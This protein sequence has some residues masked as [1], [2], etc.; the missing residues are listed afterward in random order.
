M[1]ATDSVVDDLMREFP[2]SIRVFFDFRMRCAGCPITRFHTVNDSCRAHG[3][4]AEMFL[5]ALR[6]ANLR[7]DTEVTSALSPRRA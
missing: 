7:N 1:I 4:D 3:I 5:V 2:A 6:R